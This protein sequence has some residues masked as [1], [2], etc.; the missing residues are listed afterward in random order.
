[1]TNLLEGV[2]VPLCGD[3]LNMRDWIYVLGNCRALG[4]APRR[5]FPD[6]LAETVAWYRDNPG[7]W[8]RL[9]ERAAL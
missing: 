6:A 1:V 5:G 8:K 7:W 4:W 9:K 2:P 3:G